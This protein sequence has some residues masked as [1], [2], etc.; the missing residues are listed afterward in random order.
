MVQI[1]FI[2]KTRHRQYKKI[3]QNKS[4]LGHPIFAK[5]K[6]KTYECFLGS[7]YDLSSI[8]NSKKYPFF[9]DGPG[10]MCALVISLFAAAMKIE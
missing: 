9:Q 3:I 7:F 2:K 1:L 8:H 5:I 10:L 4:L 6:T